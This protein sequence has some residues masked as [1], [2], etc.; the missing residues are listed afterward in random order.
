M[1]SLYLRQ[2]SKYS[3]F[4]VFASVFFLLLSKLVTQRLCQKRVIID[5]S[6]NVSYF[7]LALWCLGCELSPVND[8]MCPFFLCEMHR[9]V[10]L[11]LENLKSRRFYWSCPW[12]RFWFLNIMFCRLSLQLRG[13]LPSRGLLIFFCLCKIQP[14]EN[15]GNWSPYSVIFL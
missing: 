1:W 11:L 4:C 10:G 5:F 8:S 12:P 14:M 3:H 15:D 6:L 7:C 2:I 9:I 13:V